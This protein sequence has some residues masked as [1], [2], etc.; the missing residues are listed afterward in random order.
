MKHNVGDKVK[1]RE[2]LKYHERYGGQTF[3]ACHMEGKVCTINEVYNT[4]YRL[5]EDTEHWCWTDEMLEDYTEDIE[6]GDTAM[7]VE[8]LLNK[9]DVETG[10]L[11][12]TVYYPNAYFEATI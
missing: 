2:S 3:F 6:K 4:Y 1:I 7:T 5:K 8:G 11:I 12:I 9:T 10:G